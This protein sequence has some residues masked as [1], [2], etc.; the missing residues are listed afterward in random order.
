MGVVVLAK[1]GE[2]SLGFDACLEIASDSRWTVTRNPA[3]T[4][5]TEP[6]DWSY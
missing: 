2:S 3:V 5:A 6:A 4:Q 1:N